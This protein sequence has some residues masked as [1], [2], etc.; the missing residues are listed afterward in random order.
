MSRATAA[1]ATAGVVC[2]LLIYFRRRRSP[3]SKPHTTSSCTDSI[4]YAANAFSIVVVDLSTPFS[5][6]AVVRAMRIAGWQ[7]RRPEEVAGEEV[8]IWWTDFGSIPWD[9]VLEARTTA[10][11][12]YLK[13]GLVRKADLVHHMRKHRVDH[14]IPSTVIGDIEN[15]DDVTDFAAAWAQA[16]AT[17]PGVE[18][19]MLKP[20]RANRGEGIAVLHRGDEQSLRRA[21]QAYPHHRDW[22][23]QEYV[24]PML[25]P[26]I[27]ASIATPDACS[28]MQGGLKFHL[29]LH[30]LAVGSLSVWVHDDPLVLLA[31]EP[32]QRPVGSLV[33]SCSSDEPQEGHADERGTDPLLPHLTNRIRQARSACYNEV[34]H[35]RSLSESFAPSLASSLLDQCRAIASDAFVPFGKGSAAFFALPHCF[36]LYGFDIAVDRDGR[37]WLLEVNSGPDLSLHGQRLQTILDTLLVDAMVVVR[38]YIFAG[39]AS[40]GATAA[41]R[42][43]ANSPSMGE[44]QGSLGCVLARP[45]S[46]PQAELK[47]FHRCLSIVGKFAH[48]MHQKAGAPVRGVQGLAMQS[49]GEGAGLGHT[50][51]IG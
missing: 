15:G 11:A 42:Q 41:M 1:V 45:C 51:R 6:A 47:R 22:L 2:A 48:A 3:H 32:W 39:N 13:T 50:H 4:T 43:R 10:S 20:S 25:L 35:T 38:K 37:A 21:L 14:R 33:S 9:C 12:Q 8:A 44:R 30:V 24:L 5:D 40:G 36:E 18:L 19:W 23:L 16:C 26:T 28:D 31:S 27:P 46:D 7:P 49:E 29:R 17:E 34:R